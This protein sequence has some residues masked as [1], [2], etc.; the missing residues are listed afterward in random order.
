MKSLE[1]Q[2]FDLGQDFGPIP[3]PTANDID[4]II[5]QA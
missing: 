1:L 3:S 4:K 2:E 5:R